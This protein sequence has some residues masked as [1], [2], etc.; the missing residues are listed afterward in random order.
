V[1]KTCKD[2]GLTSRRIPVVRQTQATDCGAACLA[3]V[4]RYFGSHVPLEQIRQLMGT[5]RDG[6]TARTIL[7]TADFYGLDGFGVSVEADGLQELPRGTILHLDFRHFVVLETIRHSH[8]DVTDPACG[9][10]RIAMAEFLRSFT[11]VAILLEPKA[12]FVPVARVAPSLSPYFRVL[13]ANRGIMA[14]ILVVSVLLQI[15]TL[16]VPALSGTL[17]D[18]SVPTGNITL[19]W[20]V[21]ASMAA[22]TLV[23]AFTAI[24]RGQLLAYLRSSMDHTTTTGL[25]EHL[26]GLPYE[27]FQLHST[28]ELLM[29]MNSAAAVRE[30]VSSSSLALVMDG[31]MAVMYLV[32]ITLI[33]RQMAFVTVALSL[34]DGLVLA[35]SRGR[36]QEILT[37][38]VLVQAKSHSYLTQL[39]AGIATLK[40]TG[41][42]RRSLKYWFGLFASE[43]R[44]HN[45]RSRLS[46]TT[47]AALGALRN[48]RP[49]VI[50]FIGA[51]EIMHHRLTLGTVFALQALVGSFLGPMSSM[52]S[53]AFQWE[54][55]RTHIDRI[56]EIMASEPEQNDTAVIAPQLRGKATME[57]VSFRYSPLAPWILQDISVNVLPGQF[58][59][60]VGQSG[61]GKSTL[62]RLL[63][64]MHTPSHGH[65]RYDDVELTTLDLRSV[66]AQ[67]GVVPQEPFLLGVSIRSNLTLDDPSISMDAVITAAKRAHIHD[68]IIAMPMGYETLVA[69]GGSNLSGGQRQRL[70]LARALIRTPSILLLDEATSALDAILELAVQKELAALSCTRIVIAQ[71]LATIRHADLILVL[72]GGRLC[73]S[74]THE[75]LLAQ[76]GRYAKLVAAQ[77]V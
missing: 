57:S 69:D 22:V 50:L 32:A 24:V 42:E 36:F 51:F 31:G 45:A 27:F 11:G 2:M 59:G 26:V 66:R 9:R 3:M 47:D 5:G 41:A 34:L 39:L 28:G 44:A 38:T 7:Q 20:V 73:E 61:S 60:I 37:E 49:L 6:G 19:A 25:L 29:R 48:A 68:D 15:L 64:G 4:L 1:K 43:L 58:V 16:A 65:V 35:I 8:V 76:H 55:V 74:G 77:H 14:R 30:A 54:T 70:A 75:E 72:D 10:R 67:L 13:L 40:A 12:D 33:D 17:I 62:G 23:Y 53:M 52:V 56:H 71:R 63:L 21:A 18:R 46:A